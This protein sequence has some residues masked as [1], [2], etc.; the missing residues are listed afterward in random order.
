MKKLVPGDLVRLVSPIWN[1]RV[2]IAKTL[3]PTLADIWHMPTG[4]VALLV[5]V[6]LTAQWLNHG[7]Y[8]VCVF[9][10][11]HGLGYVNDDEVELV[12]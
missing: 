4:Q 8:A 11:G 9:V 6:R 12:E 2:A 10:P 7:Y 3:Q 5:S 1:N